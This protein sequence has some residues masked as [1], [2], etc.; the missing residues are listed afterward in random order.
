M[1]TCEAEDEDE[2]QRTETSFG[3][4]AADRLSRFEFAERGAGGR[5]MGDLPG[6]D[7]TLKM[8]E[9]GDERRM[10]NAAEQ[11]RQQCKS[12]VRAGW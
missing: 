2:D 1:K 7:E 8:E 5:R 10:Q 11:Q 12:T 4:Y 3:D 9:I 6:A